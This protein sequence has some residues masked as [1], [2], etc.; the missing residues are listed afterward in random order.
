MQNKSIVCESRNECFLFLWKVFHMHWLWHWYRLD[1]NFWV[2]TNLD[3]D[4]S[5]VGNNRRKGNYDSTS[6]CQQIDWFSDDSMAIEYHN[7]IC[8]MDLLLRSFPYFYC[9]FRWT[10]CAMRAYIFHYLH[11]SIHRYVS[12]LAFTFLKKKRKEINK[13][14]AF[15]MAYREFFKCVHVFHWLL[16]CNKL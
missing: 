11:R 6:Y 12:N 16:F 14:S 5:T 4:D 1:S 10:T 2:E 8:L 9:A 15:L 7:I 13:C 3:L